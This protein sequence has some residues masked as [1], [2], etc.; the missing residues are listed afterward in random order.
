MKT[1]SPHDD[2]TPRLN[3]YIVCSILFRKI[4]NIVDIVVFTACRQRV[5]RYGRQ[6]IHY[7][8]TTAKAPFT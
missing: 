5:E 4:F 3:D 6:I 1:K 2:K 8:M 7:S